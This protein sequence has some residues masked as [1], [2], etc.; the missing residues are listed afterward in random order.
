MKGILPLLVP[1]AALIFLVIAGVVLTIFIS[2]VI[3]ILRI[4]LL[5]LLFPPLVKLL[6]DYF[7]S[8]IMKLDD[9]SSLVV[10]IAFSSIIIIVVYMNF[11]ALLITTVILGVLYIGGRYMVSE[12]VKPVFEFSKWFEARRR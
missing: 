6:A 7:A 12:A 4:V 5:V 10:G 11:Y 9:V 2:G 8:Y 3:E 1:I